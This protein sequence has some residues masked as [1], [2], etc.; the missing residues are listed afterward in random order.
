MIYEVTPDPN[1]DHALNA[2]ELWGSGS[3]GSPQADQPVAGPELRLDTAELFYRLA[4]AA[5]HLAM[6]RLEFRLN[7][8]RV[9][10]C[11]ACN[12]ETPGSIAFRHKPN[13]EA[14]EILST[15]ELLRQ[16]GTL[17]QIVHERGAVS[18]GSKAGAIDRNRSRSAFAEPWTFRAVGSHGAINLIDNEGCVRAVVSGPYLDRLATA[19]RITTCVNYL[20]GNSTS[21]IED[22]KAAASEGRTV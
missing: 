1:E 18:H 16:H 13:C 7:S 22:L 15:V 8:D 17:E 2:Q 10:I 3:A 19:E 12:E 11:T 5:V 20:A 21:F 4:V 9:A 6:A 14:N